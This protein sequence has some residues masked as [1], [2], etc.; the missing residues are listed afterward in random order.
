MVFASILETLQGPQPGRILQT[1]R[2]GLAQGH[3]QGTRGFGFPA[4]LSGVDATSR[5]FARLVYVASNRPQHM[6]ETSTT[7]EDEERKR[8]GLVSQGENATMQILRALMCHGSQN[9]SAAGAGLRGI[10]NVRNGCQE[11]FSHGHAVRYRKRRVT[12]DNEMVYDDY[13]ESVAREIYALVG[14]FPGQRPPS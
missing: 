3:M 11:T 13:L 12:G 7:H 6:L 8:R 5:L 14:W 10:S 4:P 9:C 1:T 2:F